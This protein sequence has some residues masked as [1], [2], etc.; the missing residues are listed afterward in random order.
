MERPPYDAGMFFGDE[1]L[2]KAIAILRD[3][4]GLLQKDLAARIRIGKGTMN[5]YELGRRGLP[6]ETLERIAEVLESETIEIWD[7]AHAIFRFNHFLERAEREN[8][9]VEELI[10][11]HEARSSVEGILAIYD[12][13]AE[14]ERELFR[15]ILESISNE[16]NGSGVLRYVVRPVSRKTAKAT[17]FKG[18]QPKKAAKA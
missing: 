4:R 10:A 18:K 8:V 1:H 5:Q 2:G 12:S 11:R 7:M 16:R 9:D 13:R 15:Q 3:R 17:R 6:E 14:K